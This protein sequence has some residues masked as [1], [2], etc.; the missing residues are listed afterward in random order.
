MCSH[1]SR[2]VLIGLA[3]LGLLLSACSGA[4][5]PTASTVQTWYIDPVR[6]QRGAHAGLQCADCHTAISLGEMSAGHPNPDRVTQDAVATFDYTACRRCHP[7]EYDAYMHGVHAEVASGVR[8]NQT[9]N[10]A[11]TCGH[12]HSPHYNPPNRTRAELIASQVAT[13]GQCHGK[14]TETYLQNY[15]GKAAANLGD[16]SSAACTDCHGAHTVVSLKSADKALEV[17]QTCHPDASVN[18]TGFLIHA[19]ETVP[20]PAAP[21]AGESMLLF[22][23]KVLLTI[24]VVGVLGFFYAHTFIWF[25][26][27]AHNRMRGS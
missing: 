18:M 15:H 24:L 1:L 5:P 9:D 20:A 23:T 2:L 26:R 25:I 6:F 11:P 4:A 17:C 8:A 22:V 3:A 13:C 7:Q 27:S 12:C 16:T 21:H 14:A 19:Q 10:P